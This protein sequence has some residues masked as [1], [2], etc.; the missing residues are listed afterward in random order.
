MDIYS[1]G[2]RYFLRSNVNKICFNLSRKQ[3]H[4]S[5]PKMQIILN[6]KIAF[7]CE[8]YL[9]NAYFRFGFRIVTQK[10]KRMEDK[11]FNFL[12]KW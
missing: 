10:K 12:W 1:L 11:V 3:S 4:V 9:A 5:K 2:C 7:L 6:V 8:K